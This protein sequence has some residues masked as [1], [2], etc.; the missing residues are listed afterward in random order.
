MI[1]NGSEFFTNVIAG[2]VVIAVASLFKPVR[3]FAKSIWLRATTVIA[4]RGRK[5]RL[6][7]RAVEEH[8]LQIA[9][10]RQWLQE[11]DQHQY[12]F[13]PEEKTLERDMRHTRLVQNLQDLRGAG[14][15]ED[16]E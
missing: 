5:K 16:A 11:Y 4:R 7:P 14:L 6:S 10:D 12:D 2:L 1:I 13:I 9:D 8:R 3:A 15:P